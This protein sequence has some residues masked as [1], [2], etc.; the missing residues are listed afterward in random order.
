MIV[1][2]KLDVVTYDVV[3]PADVIAR[4]APRH[5]QVVQQVHD[6]PTQTTDTA[7]KI[8]SLTLYLHRVNNNITNKC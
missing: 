6:S 4:G 1:S 7:G 5:E 3:F 8:A 2:L